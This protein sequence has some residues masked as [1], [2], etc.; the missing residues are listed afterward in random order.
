MDRADLA[1]GRTRA[2]ALLAASLVLA[3]TTW[4]SA[5]AVVPQ[6][7]DDWGLGDT[8]AAWLTIAVQLGFV[9]GA[10]VSAALNVADVVP[11]RRVDPRGRGRG[12]GGQRAAGVVSGA[13]P[14]DPAALPHRLL[15]RRRVPARAQAH[16]HLV[17]PRPRDGARDPGRRA[18][19]RLGSAAP[20]QRARRARL[21]DR[22]LRDL[23]ADARGR[24]PGA[25]GARRAVP[26][27]AG[28]LRPAPGPSRLRQP[29]RP[30]G[31]PRVLRPHVGALRH[32][33]LVRRLLLDGRRRRGR[34]GL[35]DLRGHRR[36]RASGA[37]SAAS[38]ATGSAGPR[39]RRSRW[40]SRAPARS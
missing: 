13:G 8:A 29:R 17:P 34:G 18:D 19:P 32:V 2:L 4:F 28:D 38:S 21:A 1:P 35:R 23:G 16:G 11:P 6:L 9:A 26:V 36:R 5:S 30:P 10:L 31:E 3:M 7:R 25:R 37:G 39:R 12:R 40:R 24:A 14:G 22:R 15:P 33:G 27:P 20:R